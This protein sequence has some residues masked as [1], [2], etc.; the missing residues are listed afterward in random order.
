MYSIQHFFKKILFPEQCL[1]CKRHGPLCPSCA[2]SLVGI[3]RIHTEKKYSEITLLEYKNKYV[4]RIIWELKYKNNQ[5]IREVIVSETLPLLIKEL[6]F[7]LPHKT[8]H[9]HCV[10]V[11]KNKKDP[12]K[13]RD[14]DHG[15]LLL[16]EYAKG[17]PYHVSL[18]RHYIEKDTAHRQVEHTN[19][20]AR[21]AHIR[22][23]IHPTEKMKK[24]QKT[25][26]PLLIID[27]VTTTG[28]T[29]NE[30]IRVMRHRYRGPIIFVAL[31]H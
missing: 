7:L 20:T 14:F 16:S 21:I 25:Q 24:Q 30:M 27:D 28:A 6:R 11:P 22:N 29:R 18:L 12:I 19:R 17:L 13:K 23:S 31:A 26:I 10:S 3:P 1:V 4:S 8:T 5:S 2:Q 9:I 15:Y